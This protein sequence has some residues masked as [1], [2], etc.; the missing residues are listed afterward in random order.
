MQ[1]KLK[2]SAEGNGEIHLS[3]PL[4]QDA[5]L[6]AFILMLAVLALNRPG[7]VMAQAQPAQ[8]RQPTRVGA[9]VSG[10]TSPAIEI[11][12]Q[13]SG[14]QLAPG[15]AVGVMA[16]ISNV[17]HAPVFLRTDDVQ[18][19]L[20]PEAE[21]VGEGVWTTSS[22]FPTEFSTPTGEQ[23][24]ISLKPNE[25]YRV[26]WYRK[27]GQGP[28]FPRGLFQRIRFIGF[29]P[30]EYPITVEAK[31][32]DQKNFKGDD[33]HTAVQSKNVLFAAPQW[34]ILLGAA[35]GGLIFTALTMLRAEQTG[36]SAGVE[37]FLSMA[38]T[39]GKIVVAL[40]GSILLS[41]IVTILLS[42]VS[43]TQFFIKVSV[44]DIWGA[45]AV[46]FLAN[47][48]GWALLDR[49]TKGTPSAADKGK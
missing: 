46:G 40:F 47:Y 49:M 20:P 17:S 48:G 31:Y 27:M 35:L 22:S 23:Q 10:S 25:T 13:S 36:G 43:E 39:L 11:K 9:T 7:C 26:F 1:R 15:A 33:Y 34:V 24:F 14:S 28:E 42:R 3:L 45:I 16:D 5:C 44:S 12:V 2:P 6:S 29:T 8:A 21:Q 37:G 19:I 41:V 30:G 32:W 4:K 18:L 38:K